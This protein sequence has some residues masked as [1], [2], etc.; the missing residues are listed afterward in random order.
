MELSLGICLRERALLLADSRVLVP[1][2]TQSVP[3]QQQQWLSSNRP[4]SYPLLELYPV[5][6]NPKLSSQVRERQIIRF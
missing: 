2:S 6:G 5:F 4:G 3:Q 1:V